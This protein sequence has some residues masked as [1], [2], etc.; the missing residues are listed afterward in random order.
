MKQ[1][2]E[3]KSQPEMG[4]RSSKDGS[5]SH[6]NLQSQNEAFSL[7][8]ACQLQEATDA[9]ASQ[10]RTEIKDMLHTSLE[11]WHTDVITK[12]RLGSILREQRSVLLAQLET[13]LEEERVRQGFFLA[14]FAENLRKDVTAQAVNAVASFGKQMKEELGVRAGEVDTLKEELR[15]RDGAMVSTVDEVVTG[16]ATRV[17]EQVWAIRD[18]TAHLTQLGESLCGLKKLHEER[19]RAQEAQ[20]SIHDAL[21]QANESMQQ[22]LAS[23]EKRLRKAET[24]CEALAS[25]VGAP[26]LSLKT[27]IKAVKKKP[28]KQHSEAFI[29]IDARSVHIPR[30][31]TIK[32][33]E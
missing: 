15:V 24:G 12:D 18:Q 17:D 20:A 9:L 19:G 30:L 16:L 25:V 10:M 21:A 5:V 3:G 23:V 13:T 14:N 11:R 22:R 27:K 26:P 4:S 2:E 29:G 32:V 31:P 33:Y 28:A 1:I 8:F 6:S 7:R